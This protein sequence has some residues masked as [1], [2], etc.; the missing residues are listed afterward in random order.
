MLHLDAPL[1]SVKPSQVNHP[2]LAM[3][4]DHDCNL[5]VWQRGAAPELRVYASETLAGLTM[6]RECVVAVDE[7]DR[8]G[9]FSD[10]P[11]GWGL[12]AFR[13]D[14]ARLAELYRQVTGWERIRVKLE[15]FGGN[16]CERFHVDHV[17]LRLICSYAGPGTEW[18]EERDVDRS[19]LTTNAVISGGDYLSP[20]RPGAR[21]RR[22]DTFDVALMKG[23]R[24]PGNQGRGL[25]HRS[26]TIHNSGTRRVLLKIDEAE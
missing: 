25:V 7:L 14:V 13:A 2:D 8:S 10:L 22:L 16:H 23:E 11:E 15:A 21:P 17:Q 9:I 18:L 1:I 24:W 5:V 19:L 26:P 20:A 4:H 12:T 6:K 3:I